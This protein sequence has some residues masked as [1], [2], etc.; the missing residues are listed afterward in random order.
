M[1]LKKL[2]KKKLQCFLI[3]L[4]LFISA[5]I[6][7]S[8]VS[9]ITSIKTYVEKYYANNK[10]YNIVLY[11]ANEN[12]K[13][14]IYNWCNNN[15]KVKDIKAFE[16][17]GSGNNIYYKN[18]K[19]KVASYSFTPLEDY[20]SMPYGLTKIKSLNSS[21]SPK[22]GEIW[23]T[24]LFADTFKV[25]LGDSIGFKV[26]GKTV[27]LKVT[28]LINDSLQPS[29]L[30]SVTLFYINKNN[31]RDFSSYLK[32]EIILIDTKKGVNASDLE[33]NLV[34]DIKVGGYGGTND[35]LVQSSIMISSIM[36]GAAVLASVLV[37]I[38]TIF[39]IRFIVWN[40]ILKEYKS[41]G[42]YKALGFSKKEI[43]KFY[44]IG[45]SLTAVLGSVLGAVCSIPVLNYTSAKFLKYIGNFNGIN[46]NFAVILSTVFIFSLIVIVNLYLIIKRTNK[47]SPVEALRTGITSSR[48]KL[49]KSFIKNNSSPFALAINDIFKY[50]KISFCIALSLTLSL[51]LIILFGNFNYTTLKMKDNSNIWFGIPKSN[52]TISSSTTTGSE[53]FNNVLN[54]VK[55]DKRVKNYVYG[56]FFSDNVEINIK[57]YN[58]KSSFCGIQSF[59]SFDSN[60]GF[61][62]IDGHNPK[63]SN[64]VCVS[65][66][67]LKDSG[68]QVGDYLELSVKGKKE[69]YLIS[70]S[71]STLMDEGYVIRIL[72]NREIESGHYNEIF[73]N[74]KDN[75]SIKD[76]EKDFNNKAYSMNADDLEPTMKNTMDS[77]PGMIVP[78][79]SLLMI[80]F[81]VFSIVI[82]FNIIIMNL[83]DNRKNFGIM[84]ALGFTSG[85]IRN[86]YLY[87]I[88]IL[89]GVSSI[90]AV[91]L[92]MVFS[93]SIFK[94]MMS[95]QDVLIISSMVMEVSVAAMFI[96]VI[97][98]VLLCGG[99]IKNTKPT[100]LIEE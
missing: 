30:V 14:D 94:A 4:L 52:I 92:N 98:T 19:L 61:T 46:I 13:N 48:K 1:W 21:N 11:N 67:I 66:N 58:I 72:K 80:S 17:Y 44:I 47:I 20:E 42:V 69:T 82:I 5:L 60:L 9:I 78:I 15:S 83:R 27:S 75:N 93:K 7:T 71:F 39:L 99:S 56:S 50:K 74:L 88:M 89:T 87:R 97:L 12:S 37:F 59:N 62:I 54:E 90:L 18:Q 2:K 23:V 38:V 35:M 70:G 68:L 95:G 55:K 10:Y 77:I 86:R 96:I 28:S 79:S 73:L 100:E 22:E 16:S 64:E 45:Y 8:S 63:S 76:F 81:A 29:T 91:T 33:K 51:S 26:N 41:I 31:I 25:S 32:T 34:S 40:N 6:F 3:G 84:K 85:E 53:E 65:L 24:Q 43:L 57:K 49:T 36:G